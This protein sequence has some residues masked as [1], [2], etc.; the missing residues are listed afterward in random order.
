MN[1]SLDAQLEAKEKEIAAQA[2]RA[3]ELADRP[4]ANQ[5]NNTGPVDNQLGKGLSDCIEAGFG[6]G[7]ILIERLLT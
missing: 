1:T 2:A 6:T 3:K 4:A 7:Y 5:G